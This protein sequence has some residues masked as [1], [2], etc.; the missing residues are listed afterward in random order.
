MEVQ[1]STMQMPLKFSSLSA[2]TKSRNDPDKSE[3]T[4]QMPLLS[5]SHP[6][7]MNARRADRP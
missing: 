4:M 1:R 5:C 6:V 2:P 3:F 7:D